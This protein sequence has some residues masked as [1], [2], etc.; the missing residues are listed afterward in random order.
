MRRISVLS[1][2]LLATLV[3]G[4][5]IS[6]P[7][8]GSKSSAEPSAAPVADAAAADMD[9]VPAG[10]VR[11]VLMRAKNDKGGDGIAFLRAR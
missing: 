3:S 4:C 7:S 6:L 1:S 11:V 10:T 5:A 2:L 9:P 8:F